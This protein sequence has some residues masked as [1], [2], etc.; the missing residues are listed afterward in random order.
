MIS[1]SHTLTGVHAFAVTDLLK[2]QLGKSM[3]A[4]S[5]KWCYFKCLQPLFFPSFPLHSLPLSHTHIENHI[6]LLN[7]CPQRKTALKNSHRWCYTH[8]P[9]SQT[10]LHCSAHPTSPS[11]PQRP[12]SLFCFLL[13]LFTVSWE[14]NQC[15]VHTTHTARLLYVTYFTSAAS[16]L[17]HLPPWCLTDSFPDI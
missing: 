7:R 14:R 15:P 17:L 1:L 13:N 11:P 4:W 10:D 16:S 8:Q 2:A 12:V 5:A 6:H 9:L 3:Q